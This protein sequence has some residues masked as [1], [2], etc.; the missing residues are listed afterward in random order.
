[1]QK[2]GYYDPIERQREKQLSREQDD[3]DL[4]SGAVSREELGKRNGFFSS[5]DLSKARV[6]RR[7]RVR[8]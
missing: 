4:L 8:P 7:G 5:L 6:G 1:M 3:L 2:A